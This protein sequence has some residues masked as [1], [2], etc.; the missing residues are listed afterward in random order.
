MLSSVRR[1]AAG[2]GLALLLIA[3]PSAQAATPTD[4]SALRSAVTA[5][6]I[7]EHLLEFQAIADANGDTRASGTPGY[8]ASLAYV[9]AQLDA[10][11]YYRTYV[12]NFEF[13][14][15]SENTPAQ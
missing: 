2:A 1:L 7:Y 3:A 6:G 10:T 12:Q 11:G 4:S 13:A 9:K 14:F 5:E 8:D 15:F